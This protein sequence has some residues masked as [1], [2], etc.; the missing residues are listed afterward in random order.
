MNSLLETIDVKRSF[1]M[2][3]RTLE[4][5]RGVSLGVAEGESLAISGMSGAG[6]STLLHVM[7]GLDR[8]TA[9]RVLY[10]GR[11]LYAAGDR[12]R[13]AV[14]A[15]KIGFVF[16]AYH[17]LPEL[18][19]LENVLLPGLSAHGAFLRGSR[20]RERA[21]MLLGRVGLSERALHRPNELSGGEQQRVAIAR[22]LMNDPELVLADE[23]TGN[24]DSRT[25]EDVLH[26]L[27]EL[28]REEGLTLVM[29]THNETVAARCGRHIELRDG[30]PVA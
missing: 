4:V 25:G 29:V 17:L 6:K 28:A 5:L 27:F 8:P 10:R 13:S 30:R 20:L 26:Y 19:V 21:A 14:R 1:V 7:G 12:E 2:G 3:S 9:G 16:Q 15:Q 18:T 11:D 22:A 23:P 24:L